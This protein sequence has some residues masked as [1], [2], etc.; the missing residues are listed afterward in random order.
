MMGWT[1]DS[2]QIENILHFK[3]KISK[4]WFCIFC[5]FRGDLLHC[6]TLLDNLEQENKLWFK[7]LTFSFCFARKENQER[8]VFVLNNSKQTYWHVISAFSHLVIYNIQILNFL[9]NLQET[10]DSY[11]PTYCQDLGLCLLDG[12]WI[13]WIGFTDHLYTALGTTRDYSTAANLHTLR[14]TVANTS[15]LSLLQSPLFV[16]WQWIL[17]QQLTVSL[18]H[19]LQISLYYSTYKAFTSLPTSSSQLNSL[20]SSVICQLSTPE[21]SIQFSAATAISSHLSPQSSTLDCQF[22]ESKSKSKLCY[23]Q[24]ENTVSNNTPIVMSTDPL[25]R[26]GF[27]YCCVHVHFHRNLFT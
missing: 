13:G 19:T 27:L 12:V 11:L 9:N 10:V 26:N 20:D 5:K 24:T 18:N 6:N 1:S 15:V 23:D 21:F 25:P 2:G 7:C 17:T 22:S 14:F 8:L 4:K 16:S 3:N